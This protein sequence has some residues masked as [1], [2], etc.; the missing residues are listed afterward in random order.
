METEQLL[1]RYGEQGFV[2][3]PDAFS[4]EE[5]DYLNDLIDRDIEASPDSWFEK[6]EFGE[7]SNTDLLHRRP[8][9]MDRFARHDATF[10]LFEAILG[11]PRFAQFDFR[12]VPPGQTADSGM[13]FHRDVSYYGDVGGRLFDPDSEYLSTHACQIV[14]LKD[15][16]DCCPC[17][18]IVPNSHEYESIEA[19]REGLGEDYEEREIRGSAG[20]AIVYNITTLHTRKPGDEDCP[21]GRRTF[22]NYQSRASSPPLT[23]WATVPEELAMSDDPGTREYYSKWTPGQIRHAN[24]N[25]EEV[26]AFYP[27][28]VEADD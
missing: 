24:E 3:V 8:E 10:P 25:Y 4:A 2:V 27:P 17:F 18:T 28:P 15:V 19:A 26:P 20:T 9:E 13:S 14:Y 11:E 23:D 21:H 1:D 22:H 5:L 16:H 12:D 6:P 7:R